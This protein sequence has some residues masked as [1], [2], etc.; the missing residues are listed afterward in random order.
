[1]GEASC[2]ATG[3]LG[4]FE[5]AGVFLDEFAGEGAPEGLA[6]GEG[7]EGVLDAGPF[8]LVAA[9]GGEED[10][11]GV[12]EG[13][14]ED[15]GHADDRNGAICGGGSGK[16]CWWARC[17]KKAMG[18]LLDLLGRLS[19]GGARCA[20]LPPGYLLGPLPGS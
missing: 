15:D 16:R 8:E 20:S 11:E 12:S 5:G 1:M 18:L 13:E 19:R 9:V 10:G 4:V 17:E 14:E 7:G 6:L 3:L 2:G